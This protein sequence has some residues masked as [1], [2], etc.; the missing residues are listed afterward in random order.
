MDI[1][2]NDTRRMGEALLIVLVGTLYLLWPPN[3]FR[4]T[5]RACQSD[6]R[7]MLNELNCGPIWIRLAWHDSGTYD[8]SIKEWPNCGGA[9]GSIRF[10]PE[11]LHGAN[12]GLSKAIGYLR[13]LKK[14]YCKISWADLIQMASAEAVEYMGGPRIPMRYGRLETQ[15]PSECPAEGNLPNAK[16]PFGDGSADP[17]SHL[18]KVFHRMGFNDQ[19]IVALSGAH[20]V[21]RAFKER[22]GTTTHGYGDT[23]ST[24]FT[25]PISVVRHDGKHGVG[26][27]GGQSWTSKWLT[28]DN[29]Y[30]TC[31][32]DKNLLRLSTDSCL[33]QDPSFK[34]YFKKYAQSQDA[35]FQDYAAVHSKLSDLGSKFKPEKGITI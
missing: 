32:A 13:P 6:I 11:I 17:A 4:R 18:R 29:S 27:P 35:F 8:E 14:K 10:D 12:A 31:E 7:R 5:L 28:F 2:F 1:P 23:G 33:Q 24:K 30:F 34:V 21:G 16:P 26:M 3:S 20:T 25:C 9:N 19:E 22:S 15:S